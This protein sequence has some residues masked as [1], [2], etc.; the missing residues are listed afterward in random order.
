MIVY[1]VEGWSHPQSLCAVN[2]RLP[3]LWLEKYSRREGDIII[4]G[5]CPSRRQERSLTGL[6]T[7]APVASVTTER[8][9]EF[10]EMV[11]SFRDVGSPC[12]FLS[13]KLKGPLFSWPG[14]DAHE[15]LYSLGMTRQVIRWATSHRVGFEIGSDAA[16]NV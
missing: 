13:S 16:E 4:E 12:S 3:F 2:I 14:I 5:W 9:V 15:I 11:G 8:S 7:L 6:Y 10:G 1:L